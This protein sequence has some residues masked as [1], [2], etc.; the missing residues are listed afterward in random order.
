MGRKLIVGLGCSWTQGEGGYTKEIWDQYNGRVNLPMH[1]SIHLI[2]MENEHSWVNLLSKKYFPK[3]EPINLGQRG[4]G[5]RG[6]AKSLYLTNINWDDVSEGVVVFLLSGFERFD[7]FRQKLNDFEPNEREHNLKHSFKDLPHYNFNTMWPHLDHNELWTAYAKMVYSEEQ[8]VMETLTNILEVQTFCKAHNLTFI[9][10]SA[11]DGRCNQD[12]TM[13]ICPQLAKQIDWASYIHSKTS[14]TSFVE[15]LVRMDG[16]TPYPG[17]SEYYRELK[18]PAKYLANC[19]HPTIAGYEAIAFEM[20]MF[21][22][23][24]LSKKTKSL[25]DI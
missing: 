14:Y 2:P 9:L 20:A 8:T 25:F 12:Y 1:E 24:K 4:I 5:N 16:L 3:Y 17:Y 15:L 10:A 18:Y 13:S 6:A 11:F 19:I 22:E 21:I 7:F 23:N